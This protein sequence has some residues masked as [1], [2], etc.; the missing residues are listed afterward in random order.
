MTGRKYLNKAKEVVLVEC[1]RR[2]QAW[3][4]IT[5]TSGLGLRAFETTIV[6]NCW[7]ARRFCG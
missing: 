5:E 6:R 1:W 4:E 3:G 7:I 2:A